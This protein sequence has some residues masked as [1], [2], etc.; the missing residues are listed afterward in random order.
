MAHPSTCVFI[1]WAAFASCVALTA[2]G[3][4][5][6]RWPVFAAGWCLAVLTATFGVIAGKQSRIDRQCAPGT[7]HHSR[8]AA[9]VPSKGI[10]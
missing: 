4:H 3:A 5:V 10:A 2:V 1:V 9:S 6:H 8:R 7:Q